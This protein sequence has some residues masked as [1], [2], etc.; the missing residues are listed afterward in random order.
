MKK[1]MISAATTVAVLGAGLGP[2]TSADAAP[3]PRVSGAMTAAAVSTSSLTQP[4]LTPAIIGRFDRYV[5][6]VDGQYRISA[7]TSVIKTDPAGAWRVRAAVKI[8]NAE[9]TGG[10]RR[11]RPVRRARPVTAP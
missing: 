4:G 1:I 8:A 7:P 11:L 10:E 2:V 3:E 9:L 5:Q 6:L